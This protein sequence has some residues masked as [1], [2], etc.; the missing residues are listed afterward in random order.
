MVRPMADLGL[1]LADMAAWPSGSGRHAANGSPPTMGSAGGCSSCW[2]ARAR[3]L[4]RHPR[5]LL[6]CRGRRVAGR[7]TAT[8]PRCSRSSRPAVRSPSP[9]GGAGNACGTSPSGYTRPA[10]RWCPPTRRAGSATSGGCGRSASPARRSSARPASLPRSRA[11]PARGE[12]TPRRPPSTS[13]DAPRCC[14]RSTGSIHDRVR[15]VELFDFEY[16]L[17]MY[18]P[19]DKRRWGYFALPVLHHDRLVG[20]VDVAADRK[21]S[22]LDVHAVH[23]DVRFTR[24]MTAA[25]NAELRPWRSGSASTSSATDDRRSDGHGRGRGGG[26]GPT[27]A[28]VALSRRPIVTRFEAWSGTSRRSTSDAFGRQWR[29]R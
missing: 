15:A 24:A 28:S 10:Y 11:R 20:K 13:K 3:C 2:A 21:A 1:Y 8:S 26:R 27:P 25:V 22:R 29:T 9:G 23:H 12:S 6:R 4:A 14:R 18:K 19:K 16:M 17:E 7:T 5:H